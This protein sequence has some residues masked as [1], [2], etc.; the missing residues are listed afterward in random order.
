[1]KFWIRYWIGSQSAASQNN[2]MKQVF[3]ISQWAEWSSTVCAFEWYCITKT[4]EILRTES[5]GSRYFRGYCESSGGSR[6]SPRRGRQLPRGDANIRICQNF[7]TLHEIEI[8]WAPRWG[9]ASLASPLDPLLESE[10]DLRG[11]DSISGE[12]KS[13][14]KTC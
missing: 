11:T 10:S 2:A 8:I 12:I 5:C 14:V 3:A 6:I 1:M 7:P 9:R 13:T 4:E